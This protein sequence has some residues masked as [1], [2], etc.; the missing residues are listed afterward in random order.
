MTQRLVVVPEVIHRLE[1][2]S[3]IVCL[4]TMKTRSFSTET[5]KGLC[6]KKSQTLVFR[7]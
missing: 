6:L 3:A 4:D 2:K 5:K 7:Q 1:L